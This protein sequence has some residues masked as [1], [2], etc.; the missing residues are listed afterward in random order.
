MVEAGREAET[1]PHDGHEDVDGDGDLDLLVT[2]M[3]G[4]NACFLN[5]GK[6]RFTNVTAAAG[7]VSKLGST[8][9]WSEPLAPPK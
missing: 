2:S 4:P 3:G 9:S 5:D 7:L 1:L 6:G 8:T